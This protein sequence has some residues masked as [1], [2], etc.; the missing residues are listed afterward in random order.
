M[1]GGAIKR[2]ADSTII[3]R[4]TAEVVADNNGKLPSP[5]IDGKVV[6]P[7]ALANYPIK[8]INLGHGND[9]TNKTVGTRTQI[10]SEVE[11]AETG[12]TVYFV[13]PA[14]GTDGGAQSLPAA[15]DHVRIFWAEE[16]SNSTAGRTAVEVT[17][18]PDTFP[19]TYR[20]V[21]DTY[22]RS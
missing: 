10:T 7:R 11:W 15:G 20:V 18:S 4:H 13:N 14:A 5:K 17:I 2:Q 3:V 22:M 1:L 19:G 8:L 21:G 9:A 6:K 16:V 12:N